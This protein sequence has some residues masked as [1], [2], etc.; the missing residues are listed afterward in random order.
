MASS[1]RRLTNNSVSTLD[2]QSDVLKSIMSKESKLSD[3][4][5]KARKR[6]RK[7]ISSS[8]KRVKEIPAALGSCLDEHANMAD[9]SD[10]SEQGDITWQEAVHGVQSGVYADAAQACPINQDIHEWV[11]EEG[12]QDLLSDSEIERPVH[13]MS[14][15]PDALSHADSEIEID[16]QAHKVLEVKKTGVFADILKENISRVKEADKVAPKLS[17]EVAFG[18]D[19]YLKESVYNS[20]MEKLAKEFPRVE[21]VEFLKVPRLDS[22]VYQVIEQSIRT[23]DQNLQLVQKSIVSAMSAL[24]PLLELGFQRA[25]SDK[26][27]DDCAKGLWA[28]VQLMAFAHNGI[29]SRRREL[30]KPSLAPIYARVLTKGHD[31]TPEWLYGGNL[32]ET[33]RKCEAS[34]KLSE[35][36]LKPKPQIQQR[37]PSTN[38]RGGKQQSR[39]RGQLRAFNPYKVVQQQQAQQQLM[40]MPMMYYPPMGF[41]SEGPRMQRP[42]FQYPQQNQGQGFPKNKMN[43]P[44]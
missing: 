26:E 27:F 30:I 37:K 22:E 41:Q 44:K 29:S 5:K 31:T 33:T 43:F 9:P 36:I 24:A 16:S 10:Q 32:L 17:P 14:D 21:N 1:S 35:K 38:F 11:D 2:E 25:D 28:S 23:N 19:K 15:D 13:N 7:Q 20:D 8:A 12:S 18:V 3:K 42:Q 40:Q 34:K 39:G 4:D 6:D